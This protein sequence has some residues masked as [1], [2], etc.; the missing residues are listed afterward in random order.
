VPNSLI[1]GKRAITVSWREA[2]GVLGGS[3]GD[4]GLRQGN[5]R[6]AAKAAAR[7]RPAKEGARSGACESRATRAQ[8]NDGGRARAKSGPFTCESCGESLR[9]AAPRAQLDAARR[10]E[11]LSRKSYESP[12]QAG[13]CS[14]VGEVPPAR[15]SE[16]L[17]R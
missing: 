7:K 3:G 10:V 6:F 1:C 9:D 13:C 4:G 11:P 15:A 12:N 2:T 17:R 5:L 8:R 14:S 16:S